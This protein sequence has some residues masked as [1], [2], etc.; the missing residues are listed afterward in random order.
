ME[1]TNLPISTNHLAELSNSNQNRVT[2]EIHDRAAFEKEQTKTY[3]SLLKEDLNGTLSTQ[4]DGAYTDQNIVSDKIQ[5]IAESFLRDNLDSS[6]DLEAL[7]NSLYEFNSKAIAKEGIS[8]NR[9]N[10]FLNGNAVTVTNFENE[11]FKNFTF[12]DFSFDE[13]SQLEKDL[14]SSPTYIR[15]DQNSNNEVEGQKEFEFLLFLNLSKKLNVDKET[16][17]SSE[18]QID[19]QKMIAGGQSSEERRDLINSLV[20]KAESILGIEQFNPVDIQQDSAAPSQNKEYYKVEKENLIQ[21]N[22]EN[23]L[24]HTL[25]TQFS[26][27]IASIASNDTELLAL[28]ENLQKNTNDGILNNLLDLL[29]DEVKTTSFYPN[30]SSIDSI[31]Q[32]EIED[33]TIRGR[34]YG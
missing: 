33:N 25:G 13:L 30:A 19:V 23:I 4:A 24:A 2:I 26:D 32:A 9:L 27:K 11:L 34:L 6:A 3:Y 28:L 18:F 29:I 16:M 10:P 17:A 21:Y 22:S 31:A 8:E 1:I 14:Q 15:T 5:N 12:A 20:P 7:R